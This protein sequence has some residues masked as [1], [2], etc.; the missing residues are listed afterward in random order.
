MKNAQTNQRILAKFKIFDN[1]KMDTYTRLKIG[2]NN[3]PSKIIG[4]KSS[5]MI[6]FM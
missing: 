1:L 5:N 2:Y 3:Y 6:Q 4:Y